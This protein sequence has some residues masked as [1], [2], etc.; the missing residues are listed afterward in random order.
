MRISRTKSAT[1][2]LAEKAPLEVRV[3][4][5]LDFLKKSLLSDVPPELL[6]LP[7]PKEQRRPQPLT[8]TPKSKGRPKAKKKRRA[9]EKE[10]IN[11]KRSTIFSGN[12][13]SQR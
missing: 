10:N 12:Q 4:A 1:K 8:G 7:M 2:K 6:K 9:T 13:E 5:E 11:L 3:E